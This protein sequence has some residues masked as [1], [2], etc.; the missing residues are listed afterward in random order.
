MMALFD[1]YGFDKYLSPLHVIVLLN[2]TMVY[3]LF[4]SNSWY[5]YLNAYGMCKLF[6]FLRYVYNTILKTIRLYTCT[7]IMCVCQYNYYNLY[8]F[9]S[10]A[11]LSLSHTYCPLAS[12]TF[13]LHILLFLYNLCILFPMYFT[14]MYLYYEIR[15]A[16]FLPVPLYL[17]SFYAWFHKLT[18]CSL[19]L[20]EEETKARKAANLVQENRKKFEHVRKLIKSD[21]DV[22]K[23]SRK[24]KK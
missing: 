11:S 18:F 12:P 23:S 22:V 16:I 15:Y 8:P 24:K 5:S 2:C 3:I 7:T 17:P 14:L 10:L 1:S 19:E 21:P 9:I 13:N 20:V 4:H 6:P